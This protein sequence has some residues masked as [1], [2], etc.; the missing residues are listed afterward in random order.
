MQVD[1]CVH[2]GSKRMSVNREGGAG[3]DETEGYTR[4]S[5][6]AALGKL[7]E[8]IKVPSTCEQQFE[9]NENSGLGVAGGSGE[10]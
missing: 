7:K 3:A 5:R 9:N 1:V 4:L 6:P 8:L 10:G 2:G